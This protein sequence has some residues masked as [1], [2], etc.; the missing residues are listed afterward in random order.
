MATKKSVKPVP[1]F[2]VG[3]EVVWESQAGGSTRAKAGRVAFVVQG[4]DKSGDAAR[5]FIFDKVKAGTHRS[6]FGGGGYRPDVSYIVEVDGASPKAKKV[7]YWPIAK[8]LE[9][10]KGKPAR[11]PT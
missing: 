7:L 9:K 1:E 8:K 4:G 2:K 5:K 3:D 6:T 11:L 10:N